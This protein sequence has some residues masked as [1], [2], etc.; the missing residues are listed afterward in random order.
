MAQF[1]LP[2]EGVRKIWSIMESTAEKHIIL[3]QT[4]E[5]HDYLCFSR[6]WSLL[7]FSFCSWT[8]VCIYRGRRGT[9][10]KASRIDHQG[11]WFLNWMPW[12][13][14]RLTPHLRFTIIGGGGARIFLVG[15][16]TSCQR[17]WRR[18]PTMGFSSFIRS[19]VARILLSSLDNE[20]SKA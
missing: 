1:A 10:C 17:S 12:K 19:I 18:R 11:S 15:C 9:A 4:L 20:D 2:R 16:V 14:R 13:G 8:P 7:S 5:R 3:R 6:F